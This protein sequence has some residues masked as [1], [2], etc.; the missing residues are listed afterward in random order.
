VRKAVADVREELANVKALTSA[1]RYKQA[2]QKSQ[3]LVNRARQTK[4]DPVLA[5][6]LAEAG[7]LQYHGGDPARAE[8]AYDE[9]VWLAEATHH[10][11][12]AM[13][14][15]AQLIFVVGYLQRRFS[16]AERWGRLAGSVLRRLG[17]G[18]DLVAAWR[19]NNL[20]SVYMSEGAL[21]KALATSLEG[22]ALKRR[23]LGENHFDVGLSIGNVA[24]I[25][26]EL[27][28]VDEA[29][30]E[31]ARALSILRRTLGPDHPILADNLASG[32]EFLNARGRWSEANVMAQQALA[33][34][35]RELDAG[36]PFLA[37]PLTA[38]GW[39]W[40]RLGDA[41]RAIPA[42][43]RALA[44]RQAKDSD[45]AGLGDTRFALGSA[46]AEAGRTPERA[47]SLVKQARDDYRKLPGTGVRI[48]EIESWITAH[49]PMPSRPSGQHSAR[50]GVGTFSQPTLSAR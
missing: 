15:G 31:N 49:D 24:I 7:D 4:Y 18:H 27:G 30:E 22:L 25:H 12:V 13:D 45:P 50:A 39:S 35:E 40:L 11:E 36:H 19:A 23:A 37:A 26:F 17:P 28:R 43:E 47:L 34:W 10:D 2:I 33:I 14:A 6:V 41:A 16:E 48:V 9:A 46:L 44:I 1:G 5:E 21:D 8:E 3:A 29:I 42:L 38:L 32:A 20:A